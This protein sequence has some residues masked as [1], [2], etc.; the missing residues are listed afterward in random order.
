MKE[1]NQNRPTSYT[2]DIWNNMTE[3]ERLTAV[4]KTTAINKIFPNPPDIPQERVPAAAQERVPAAAQERVPA[5]AQERVP[6]AAQEG[7]PAAAQE[8][9]PAAAQEGI[10]TC[11]CSRR[12]H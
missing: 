12:E 2:Q 4:V 6:A 5:A 10:Y 7:V 8:R 9:V 3:E 11:C 1:L